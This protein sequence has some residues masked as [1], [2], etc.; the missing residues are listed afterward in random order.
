[1]L[2]GIVY[3]LR[4]FGFRDLVGVDPADTDTPAMYVQHDLRRLFSA[5]AEE[6][7][8]DVNDELHRRVIVVQ[9]QYL[10]KRGALGFRA[11]ANDD[12]G[13][14][15]TAAT[16]IITVA[17]GAAVVFVGQPHASHLTPFGPATRPAMF[18]I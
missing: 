4:H 2:A 12:A 1:M 7:L 14:T 8:Q 9:H 18:P 17:S 5:L 3:D 10:V 16:A 13:R 15:T 6:L 11:R